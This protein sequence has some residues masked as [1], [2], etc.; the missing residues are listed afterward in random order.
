MIG[1]RLGK[2]NYFYRKNPELS[3]IYMPKSVMIGG[4]RARQQPAVPSADFI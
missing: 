4:G 3:G 1:L 2:H